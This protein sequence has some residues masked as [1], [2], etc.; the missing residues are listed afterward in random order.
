MSVPRSKRFVAALMSIGMAALFISAGASVAGTEG[1]TDAKSG[2]DKTDEKEQPRFHGRLPMYF[3][4]VVSETQREKIYA[5]QAKY[6]E[7]IRQLQEQLDEL[8]ARRG[9]E[10]EAVLTPE[11]LA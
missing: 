8:K 6:A 10:I 5:I 7:R 11:Q 1:S 3:G 4:S 9:T 2:G